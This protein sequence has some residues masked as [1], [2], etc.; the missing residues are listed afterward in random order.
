MNGK[1]S[2]ALQVFS[3]LL[4]AVAFIAPAQAL[5]LSAQFCGLY[6]GQVVDAVDPNLSGRVKVLV[7]AVDPSNA[8]WAVPVTSVDRQFLAPAPGQ[9][10]W[11]GY[12]GCDK[13]FPVWMGGTKATCV[14]T[15]AGRQACQPQ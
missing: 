13:K 8:L 5:M 10:V 12:E 2:Q 4:V 9:M 15:A 11:I 1:S 7:P 14:V 3:S 6:R